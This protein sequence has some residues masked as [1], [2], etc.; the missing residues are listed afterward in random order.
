MAKILLIDDQEMVRY[1]V[2]EALEGMGHAVSEAE[3]GRKGLALFDETTFDLVITDLFMPVLDG[4]ELL[5]EIHQ[6]KPDQSIIVITAGGQGDAID[7]L[8][9]KNGLRDHEILIKPF[10]STKL[11]EVVR[12]ALEV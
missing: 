6:R 4:F 3:E 10:D 12:Q 8:N 1:S 7:R 9:D 5:N 2:R 11:A